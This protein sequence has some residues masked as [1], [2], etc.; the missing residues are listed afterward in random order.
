MCVCVCEKE[1]ERESERKRE[2][3]REVL[4]TIRKTVSAFATACSGIW[5][6][7][8]SAPKSWSKFSSDLWVSGCALAPSNTPLEAIDKH[9]DANE[10]KGGG[11]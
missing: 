6:L 8:E 5:V 11:G 3:E 2:R 1:R 4:L 10:Y 9:V 7:T